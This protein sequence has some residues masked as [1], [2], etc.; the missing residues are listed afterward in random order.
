MTIAVASNRKK[1]SLGINEITLNTLKYDV[2]NSLD[3]L[4]VFVNVIKF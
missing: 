1:G 4:I 3:N 2:Q